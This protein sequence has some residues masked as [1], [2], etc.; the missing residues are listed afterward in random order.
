MNEPGFEITS[1]PVWYYDR[2]SYGPEEIGKP[3]KSQNEQ[4]G[5]ET[6]NGRGKITG[7]LYGGCLES[8]Y[9][10]YTGE[11]FADEKEIYTEYNIL[12]TLDEWKEKI[13]FIETSEEKMHPDKLE[14][15]LNFFRNNKILESVKGI[16]VGKPIDEE[17]YEEYKQ[18]Y[19]KVFKDL[20]TPVL[21]NVNFGHSVPRCI[22]PYD[23]EATIDFDQKNI[24][25]TSP[26]LE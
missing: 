13:L 3:R 26:I 7:K 9:D 24:V 18:V 25:I 10:A 16:I 4:H 6:L 12:P 20:Q 5:P 22:I 1:S 17:Y 21:Y 2:E 15:I 19:K 11:R 23:A 8:L 14:T